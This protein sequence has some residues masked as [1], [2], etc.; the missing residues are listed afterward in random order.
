MSNEKNKEQTKDTAA[1][2]STSA[3]HVQEVN[4]KGIT[5]RKLKMAWTIVM[6]IISVVYVLPVLLVFMN[7][8][9]SII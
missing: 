1:K 8:F 4:K 6:S 7:S 9:K 3:G 5:D 2:T